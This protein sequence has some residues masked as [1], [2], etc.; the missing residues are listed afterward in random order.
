M[1]SLL[2]AQYIKLMVMLHYLPTF[3]CSCPDKRIGSDQN[4]TSINKAYVQ[5]NRHNNQVIRDHTAFLKNKFNLEVDAE[6]KILPIIYRTTKPHKHPS[7][8]SRF[9][10]AVP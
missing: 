7:K 5:V 3:L 6:N 4:T 1:I 9:I 8:A 10:I 2:L